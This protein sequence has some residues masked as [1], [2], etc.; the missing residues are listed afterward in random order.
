MTSEIMP[1]TTPSNQAYEDQQREFWKLVSVGGLEG[2]LKWLR[3]VEA[4]AMMDKGNRAR[5]IAVLE[6][7][8][9]ERNENPPPVGG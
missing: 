2:N 3:S 1:E 6:K 5:L 9:K 8:I 7:L 4:E